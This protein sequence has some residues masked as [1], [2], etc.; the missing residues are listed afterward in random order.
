MSR[1]ITAQQQIT[2]QHVTQELSLRCIQNTLRTSLSCVLYL[3]GCFDDE[4][5]EDKQIGGVYVKN[6]K[7]NLDNV[8]A[9][10]VH[11]WI[12]E[13]LF[14][15]INRQ[16]LKA[17]ILSI[18]DFETDA[19][20]ECYQYRF[21]YSDGF[22]VS[23][24]RSDVSSSSSVPL[25]VSKE[26]VKDQTT[27][28]LQG[29]IALTQSLTP[30]PEKRYFAMKLAYFDDRV[31]EG[32]QPL[33]FQPFAPERDGRDSNKFAEGANVH[34]FEVGRLATG[35]H[36]LSVKVRTVALEPDETTETIEMV[37]N[38]V[39]QKQTTS[40]QELAAAFHTDEPEIREILIQLAADVE[41]KDN[42]VCWRGD[43]TTGCGLTEGETGEECR[44]SSP[45]SHCTS[46]P[47]ETLQ[48]ADGVS[49]VSLAQDVGVSSV[50]TITGSVSGQGTGAQLDRLMQQ[51]RDL[52]MS[53]SENGIKFLSKRSVSEATGLEVGVVHELV[54]L[55]VDEGGWLERWNPKKGWKVIFMR[56]Q[57][58]TAN[59]RKREENGGGTG[60]TVERK[61]VR[62][63]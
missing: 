52:V 11:S 51:L 41:L 9:R 61:R 49:S 18:H 29:L 8:E 25:G 10:Q 23:L 40:L 34:E 56:E 63:F 50:R 32:Y 5:F 31:P 58:E 28:L 36:G 60:E 54:D 55:L 43:A 33:H 7:G 47:S 48:T 21:D 27:R 39:K 30:L 44:V 13:G 46:F 57:H 26:E 19:L 38:W 45:A 4:C 59:Y 22:A 12:E 16:F 53:H 24:D 3:R 1:N 62:T 35:H 42:V 6:L 15:A 37:A 14:D 17:L 2:R 20:V